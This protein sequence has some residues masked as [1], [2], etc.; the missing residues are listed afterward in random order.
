MMRVAFEDLHD[1]ARAQIGDAH[2]L[3]GSAGGEQLAIGRKVEREDAV[4][5]TLGII[6]GELAGGDV[7]QRDVAAARWFAAA[8]G[9]RF[10]IGAEGDAVG[11]VGDE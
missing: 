3:V 7:P 6:L 2:G 4:E 1:F 10:A 9:E 5:V 8:D 11:A